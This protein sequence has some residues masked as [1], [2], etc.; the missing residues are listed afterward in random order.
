MARLYCLLFIYLHK[1]IHFT[2]D[3][4]LSPFSSSI[5]K[6]SFNFQDS[7]LSLVIDLQ[8]TSRM[9]L[10]NIASEC[11]CY[12]HCNFCNTNL[13]VNVPGNITFNAVTV[14]CGHCSNLLSLYTGALPQNT[15]HLQNVH[16]QNIFYQYLSED[17]R[18]SKSNEVSASDSSSE[19][20]HP[21]TLSVH[22]AKGKRQ[23][24]PSAY[25]KFINGHISLT[26][27]LG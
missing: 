3:S 19:N 6:L 18:S 26:P 4:N 17:S 24:A 16:K 20:E 9:S 8:F 1:I 11:V 13:A 27:N 2:Q 10:N 25:N 7:L 14:K 21:K 23:R 15:H 22:A 5:I 12:V